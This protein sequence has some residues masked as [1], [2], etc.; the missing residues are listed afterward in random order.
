MEADDSEDE[1]ER[2]SVKRKRRH[3]RDADGS[4]DSDDFD[5]FYA[6]LQHQL[7]QVDHAE[8]LQAR[9][10]KRLE[11]HA[12]LW[13]GYF[14]PPI[15]RTTSIHYVE[16]WSDGIK[17]QFDGIRDMGGHMKGAD[18]FQKTVGAAMHGQTP[19]SCHQMID[20][21]EKR[22]GVDFSAAIIPLT[23]EGYVL[24][25]YNSNDDN[26]PTVHQ[27]MLG[28]RTRMTAA[29]KA[30][31]LEEL[32]DPAEVADYGKLCEVLPRIWLLPSEETRVHMKEA[33]FQATRCGL[34]NAMVFCDKVRVTIMD[35]CFVP[36]SLGELQHRELY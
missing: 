16:S 11:V 14:L 20:L 26:D 31:I 3:E 4:I 2:R 28:I 21:F 27:R 8:R 13:T 29:C 15:G 17:A 23:D 30:T 18:A 35:Y 36:T 7:S 6:T 32:R 9:Y 1:L 10:D 12:E 24:W 34:D 33:T 22:F 19:M 5:S 25:V